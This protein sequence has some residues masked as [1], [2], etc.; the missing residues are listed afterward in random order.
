[1][2]MRKRSAGGG[3]EDGCPHPDKVPEIEA[4]VVRRGASPEEVREEMALAA[5]EIAGGF[6]PPPRHWPEWLWTRIVR[7]RRDRS[8]TGR[9]SSVAAAS[10]SPGFSKTYR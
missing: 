2:K 6:T 10:P 9:R 5:A 3:T 7:R 4:L 1:M 8:A